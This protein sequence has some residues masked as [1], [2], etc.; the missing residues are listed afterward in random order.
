MLFFGQIAEAQVIVVGSDTAKYENLVNDSV[1]HKAIIY[2]KNTGTTA[3]KVRWR[4]R[5]SP[6]ELVPSGWF[7]DGVCDWHDCY[8]LSQAE[9]WHI[10]DSIAAGDTKQI[11]VFMGRAPISD[12]GC[13]YILL[14]IEDLSGN[15]IAKTTH[16][17]TSF[18]S[19][20]SCW[21]LST[22]SFG[23]NNLVSVYPN[24]T[25]NFINLTVNDKRVKSIQLSNIIGKQIKRVDCYDNRSS[26]QQMSLLG[27]PDGIYIL[28]FK[29]EDGKVLG[30]SRIT[31]Q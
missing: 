23:S 15:P 10:S 13:S 11:Y 1:Q 14:D 18:S 30:I 31:K 7:S 8:K 9:T 16:I 22:K 2:L 12:I 20:A 3:Q 24:P 21:P 26:Q 17:H 6:E 27:L 25:T 19:I 29:S 4:K 28:Q 5:P